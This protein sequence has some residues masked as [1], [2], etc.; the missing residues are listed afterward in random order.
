MNSR[1]IFDFASLYAIHIFICISTMN[2]LDDLTLAKLPTDIIRIIFTMGHVKTMH[3]T[4]QI[5]P[6]WNAPALEFLEKNRSRLPPIDRVSIDFTVDSPKAD[7]IIQGRYYHYFGL[8]TMAECAEGFDINARHERNH[9][10]DRIAWIFRRASRIELLQL[11]MEQTLPNKLGAL[12][13]R[14]ECVPVQKLTI[15]NIESLDISNRDAVVNFLRAHDVI[16]IKAKSRVDNKE[17]IRDFVVKAVECVNEMDLHLSTPRV[18]E[19]EADDVCIDDK[20]EVVGGLIDV[21][22]FEDAPADAG[23]VETKETGARAASAVLIPVRLAFITEIPS[24][25]T[26]HQ[27]VLHEENFIGP[28]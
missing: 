21:A 26:K 10:D 11:N 19:V 6:N 27:P 16:R 4:K 9:S 25:H 12:T 14:L 28:W 1:P 22:V 17:E 8:R 3:C 7:A 13:H 15:D 5:S 2:F 23:V 18:V 20:V 24:V